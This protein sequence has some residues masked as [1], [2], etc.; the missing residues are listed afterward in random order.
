MDQ[1]LIDLLKQSLDPS[2]Q[3]Q[4]RR[5]LDQDLRVN[6]PTQQPLGFI[7]SLTNISINSNYPSDLRLN[8][9]VLLRTIPID[10]YNNKIW[11]NALNTDQQRQIL[12]QLFN[13]LLAPTQSPTPP[14]IINQLARVIADLAKNSREITLQSSDEWSTVLRPILLARLLPQQQQPPTPSNPILQTALLDIFVALPW[15][16]SSSPVELESIV[17]SSLS[18]DHFPLRLAAL[19][20]ICV[21]TLDLETSFAQPVLQAILLPLP[22]H[23]NQPDLETALTYLIEFATFND[24]PDLTTWIEPLL[25]LTLDQNRIISTRSTALEC[26]ITLIESRSPAYNLAPSLNWLNPVFRALVNLMAEIDEDEHWSSSLDGDEEDQDAIYIQAEQALDRLTQEVAKTHCDQLFE[27]ILSAVQ[28]PLPAS[29]KAKHAL[30]SVIAVTGDGLAE[31]FSLATEQIYHVL[32]AGFDDPHPRVIY[33]AIYAI[34]QLASPLKITFSTKPVHQ[35]VLS[36]L[37]RCLE[38]TSQPRLQAFSAKALINVLW[39]DG[40]RKVEIADEMVGPLLARLI[41]LCESNYSDRRSLSNKIRLDA[42]DAIGKLFGSMSQQG[43]LAFF[44][45]TIS[46]LRKLM[47]EVDLARAAARSDGCELYDE[48][49]DETELK[50]FEAISRLAMTSGEQRFDA[51]ADWWASRMLNVLELR[52]QGQ[53]RILSSLAGLSGGMNADRFVNQGF[54]TI[55]IDRLIKI[56]HAKPDIS[57]SALLDDCHEFDDRQWE[58]VV[59]GEQTFGIK[60]AELAD[61]ELSLKTLI[62]LASNIGARLIPHCDQIVAAVIPLLKFY[63]SDEVRESAM[64]LLPLLV[65]SAKASGMAVQQVEGVST[66][67]CDSIRLAFSAE[68]LDAG[69]LADSLLMA[70]AECAGYQAPSQEEVKQ[71]AEACCERIR[72][73]I[74]DG[75]GGDDEEREEGLRRLFTGISRVLRISVGMNPE[76]MWSHLNERVVDWTRIVDPEPS[77]ISIGLKRLGFRLVGAFVKFYSSTAGPELIEKVGEHI[78]LGFT[79]Q[80]ECVRGL[81]PFIVGLCAERNGESPKPVYVEL[82]K[83]S[84]NL[85]VTGLQV[86]SRSTGTR[87]GTFGEA[88]QVARENC[89]SALAKIVRNP[90]GLVIEVDKILPQWIDALPIEIDV[91]EVEPSYGLLLELIARGHE[92]VDP[93]KNEICRI[94][95]VIQSLLSAI[96]NDSITFECRNSLSVALRAYLSQL[97]PQIIELKNNGQ[98]PQDSVW[99]RLDDFLAGHAPNST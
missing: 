86:N 39:D 51:D 68:T 5:N 25:Q 10:P 37:L 14:E 27:L 74:A 15:L 41:S 62:L 84:M 69:N 17:L 72:R 65:Q 57:I 82:I 35:Q 38:N 29:W 96:M 67:F 70:W 98:L 33:A 60:S 52:P 75:T 49:M 89:V 85:L 4:A 79:H 31:S 28:P 73:V 99:T 34:A 94:E 1:Q 76:W 8:A 26:L 66:S 77:A 54:L 9:L 24:I 40:F 6:L 13:A 3:P 53:T 44:D 95:Q 91:E 81:A 16:F 80:D 32:Q 56:C 23:P 45:T 93:T 63:F 12:N 83:S 48:E 61:K 50:V 7:N 55:L 90:E 92:S 30:L 46:T 64:V 88:A 87:A 22:S 58:S 11:S 21:L 43:A 47:E 19:Q 78:L 20:A 97:P 2:T 42:L 18:S 36:W 59:I 71:M